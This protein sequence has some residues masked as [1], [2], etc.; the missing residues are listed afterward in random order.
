MTMCNVASIVR[1]LQDRFPAHH[2]AIVENGWPYGMR[3][4]LVGPTFQHTWGLVD[5]LEHIFGVREIQ[6]LS[7][8]HDG[9]VCAT[10]VA[11]S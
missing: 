10:I 4:E 6:L 3:V 2:V 11:L 9:V 7:P 5:E 1:H 8:L